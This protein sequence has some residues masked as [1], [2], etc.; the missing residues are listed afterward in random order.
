MLESQRHHFDIPGDVSFLSAASYS[1]LPLVVQDAGRAGVARKGRPWEIDKA[2]REHQNERARE[3]AARLI[4][5]QSDCVAIVPSVSYGFATAAAVLPVEAGRRVLVLEDDH[6]SPVLAWQARAGRDGFSVETVARPQDGDWTSHVLDAITR[7]G[8]PD[9]AIAS[10]SLVHWADGSLLDMGKIAR[11]LKACG[12]ALLV[13]ATQAVGVVEIDVAVLDPDF[14]MFPTYKW[15]LGPYGRAFLYVARRHHG[16]PPLEETS[17]GRR[18]VASES[19]VYFEDLTH[20]GDARR[21]DMGERDYFITMEMASV[22][23]ELVEAWGI[24]AIAQRACDLNRLL[25]ARAPEGSA[26]AAK[27]RS[28][29]ILSLDVGAERAKP[30]SERLAAERIHVT[31][32]LGLLRVSPHVYNEARDIERLC[33]ALDRIGW[34]G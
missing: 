10:L 15:L 25:E 32:R 4:G 20:V 18:K 34:R 8:A 26:I 23:M 17:S 27:Y 31:P 29:H 30:V 1:P 33:D 2:F 21:F 3:A 13:D 14:L 16:G 24:A 7:P 19:T 9:I 5:A 11:E 28:A 22:G 6:A 12:A